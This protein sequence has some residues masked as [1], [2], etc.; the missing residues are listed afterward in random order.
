MS[1]IA[2]KFELPGAQ[3]LQHG[4]AGNTSTFV[5]YLPANGVDTISFVCP[6]TMGDG[7]DLVVEVKTAND[8][9][10][11]SATALTATVPL[12]KDGVKQT[13]AK[14]FTEASSSGTYVYILEVP[15][16]LIPD[17]KYI[18]IYA[19]AGGAGSKYSCIAIEDTYYKG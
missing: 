10:G 19:S 13:S 12:Y 15:A 7:T 3:V 17:G 8:S 14:S 6:V 4:T 1:S 5:G 9:S 11:T 16:I 18:G 2:E